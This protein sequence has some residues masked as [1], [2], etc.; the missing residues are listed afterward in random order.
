MATIHQND[1]RQGWDFA[2][3]LFL[4]PAATSWLAATHLRLRDWFR[5]LGRDLRVLADGPVT[6]GSQRN[7]RLRPIPLILT[8]RDFAMNASAGCRHSRRI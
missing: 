4:H 3:D 5:T 6:T 2:D 7:A 8:T 1:V